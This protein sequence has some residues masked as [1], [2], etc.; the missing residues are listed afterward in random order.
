MYIILKL[1][2]GNPW[3]QIVKGCR[4]PSILYDILVYL[5]SNTETTADFYSAKNEVTLISK[6]END[7]FKDE[8]YR[9]RIMEFFEIALDINNS[10]SNWKLEKRAANGDIVESKYVPG[11]GKYYRITVS[12]YIVIIIK[13]NKFLCMVLKVCYILKQTFKKERSRNT[14]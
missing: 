6:N 13:V 12:Q 7:L 2:H 11:L 3:L 4:E 14:S 5:D 9:K 8:E 10:T 1:I